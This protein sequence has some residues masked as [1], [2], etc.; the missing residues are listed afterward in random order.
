MWEERIKN[1]T[2]SRQSTAHQRNAIRWRADDGLNIECWLGSFAGDFP[3][4]PEN[5]GGGGGREI[6]VASYFSRFKLV[7]V[8]EQASLNLTL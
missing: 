2:K 4:D 7:S 1:T 3:G 5:W 6:R 8:A